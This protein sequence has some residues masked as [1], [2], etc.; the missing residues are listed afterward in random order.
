MKKKTVDRLF[1][2]FDFKGVKPTPLERD[3]GISNGYFLKQKKNSGSLGSDLIEK[4]VDYFPS[5]NPTWLLKG[6]GQM[7]LLHTPKQYELDPLPDNMVREPST[8]YSKSKG[9]PLIPLTAVAGMGDGGDL[10]IQD[11]DIEQRY[12]VPEFA[13]ADYLIRVKG[14][15]MFPKYYPG[16]VIACQRLIKSTFIQWNKAYVLDTDQGILVKRIIKAK[17]ATKWI[18]RSENKEYSDIEIQ[19]DEVRHIALVLGVIRLE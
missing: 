19:H 8:K 7:D 16:D 2:Y 11:T 3:M 13:K 5:L 9:I 12:I 10:I 4:I 15:S 18:L 14:S 6:E 17:D 1:E